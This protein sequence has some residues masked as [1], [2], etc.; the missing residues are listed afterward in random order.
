MSICWIVR[1][2]VVSQQEGATDGGTGREAVAGTAGT[3]PGMVQLPPPV[4]FAPVA[5]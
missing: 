4:L 1:A 2:R 5:A 3:V